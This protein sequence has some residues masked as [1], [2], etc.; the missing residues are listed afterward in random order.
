MPL[1][2]LTFSILGVACAVPLSAGAWGTGFEGVE[3]FLASFGSACLGGEG[4][5]LEGPKM[6]A[7]DIG[8][9]VRSDFYRILSVTS[10]IVGVRQGNLHLWTVASSQTVGRAHERHH[11][12]GE[13]GRG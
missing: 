4:S 1:T 6:L 2:P 9:L 11:S 8:L 12:A 10:G 5:L 13:N 3:V 7:K